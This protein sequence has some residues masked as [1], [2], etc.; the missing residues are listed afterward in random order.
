MTS[1]LTKA[2]RR[3]TGPIKI[4][5]K[6]QESIRAHIES[7]FLAVSGWKDPVTSEWQGLQLMKHLCAA[8][9]SLKGRL[10]HD[11]VVSMSAGSVSRIGNTVIHVTHCPAWPLMHECFAES[12]QGLRPLVISTR[13]GAAQAEALA[14]QVGMGRKVEV[15]DITQFLVANMLE[16]T[17]FDGNQ[18]RHTF[19]ELVTRYN[20]I[21]EACETDPSL[22]IEVA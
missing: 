6:R 5:H 21:I 19:E 8:V 10:D 22:K 9:L 12:D 1:N 11:A 2:H 20:A 4:R 13:A 3:R 15:L 17:G 18:R 14:Q 16:W 7:L